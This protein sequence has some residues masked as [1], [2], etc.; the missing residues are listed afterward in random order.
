M[1]NFCQV[2]RIEILLYKCMY[3]I[4]TVLIFFSYLKVYIWF[5]NVL[6][7]EDISFDE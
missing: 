3:V 6:F 7:N 4:Y 1:S 5:S 2:L